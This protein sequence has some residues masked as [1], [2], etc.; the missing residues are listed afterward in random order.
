[1]LAEDIEQIFFI[2]EKGHVLL[3]GLKGFIRVGTNYNLYVKALQGDGLA[4]GKPV[5]I[6]GIDL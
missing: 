4:P 6:D 3:K 1:M 5:Y 2:C